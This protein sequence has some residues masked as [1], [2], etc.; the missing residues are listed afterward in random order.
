MDRGGT[1]LGRLR[2][3]SSS[4]DLGLG[5]LQAGLA[6]LHPSFEASRVHGGRQLADA[7]EAAQEKRLKVSLDLQ[8]CLVWLRT[9]SSGRLPQCAHSQ[10]SVC[11]HWYA[12]GTRLETR[13]RR[14]QPAP[15]LQHFQAAL[16]LPAGNWDGIGSQ[17]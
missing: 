6:K 8:R 4:L 3:T 17:S 16:G 7:Q 2:V 14:G 15:Q 9:G 11:T 13:Q 10:A 5:L 1:F 12:I